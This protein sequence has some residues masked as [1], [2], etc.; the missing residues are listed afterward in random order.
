[1][2]GFNAFRL[3]DVP[4]DILQ[5]GVMVFCGPPGFMPKG[6]VIWRSHGRGMGSLGA[7]D[8]CFIWDGTGHKVCPD[9]IDDRLRPWSRSWHYANITESELGEFWGKWPK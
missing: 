7:V 2:Y 4:P 3:R 6:D 8:L 5:A 1:V 9:W